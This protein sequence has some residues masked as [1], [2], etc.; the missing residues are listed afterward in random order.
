[1]LLLKHN[2]LGLIVFF[3]LQVGKGRDVGLNQFVLFEGE[4]SGGNEEHVLSRDI[5]R[6]GQLFDFFKMLSFYFTTVCFYVCT[7]MTVLT[8][9]I[10]LYGRVYLVKGSLGGS[11]TLDVGD[12]VSV[13]KGGKKLRRKEKRARSP[14]GAYINY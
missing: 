7:M 8:V 14:L 5:Y 11:T 2:F 4:V 3:L 13:I 6:V 10:L 9:Y 12:A 1:M